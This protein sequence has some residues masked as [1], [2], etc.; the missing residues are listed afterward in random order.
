M[1][2][3]DGAADENGVL[4]S[5]AIEP[6]HH[7]LSDGRTLYVKARDEAIKTINKIIFSLKVKMSIEKSKLYF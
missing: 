7:K 5:E 1:V 6:Y 2:G 4:T 3:T